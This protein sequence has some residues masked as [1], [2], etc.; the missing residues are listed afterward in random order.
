MALCPRNRSSSCLMKLSINRRNVEIL[1]YSSGLFFVTLLRILAAWSWKANSYIKTRT[2]IFK[3]FKYIN[4]LSTSIFIDLFY[5]RLTRYQQIVVQILNLSFQ[6]N[7]ILLNVALIA[8][9]LTNINNA[10]WNFTWC[11]EKLNWLAKAEV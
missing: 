4:K 11:T 2:N 10:T 7:G 6:F 3:F 5:N 8:N 1:Y 9:T